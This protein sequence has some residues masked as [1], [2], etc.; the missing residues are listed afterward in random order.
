M[1][2]VRPH[3][4]IRQPKTADSGSATACQRLA[5]AS[6]G[7]AEAPMAMPHTIVRHTLPTLS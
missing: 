6:Q 5:Y 4:G 7:S 2:P 1:A 3:A